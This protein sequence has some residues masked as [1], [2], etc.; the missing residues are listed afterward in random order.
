M[1]AALV[2]SYFNTGGFASAGITSGLCISGVFY[3]ETCGV[4]NAFLENIIRDLVTYAEH[5]MRTTATAMDMVYTLKR[6]GKTLPMDSVVKQIQQSTKLLTFL[7]Q[8]VR[9]EAAY[10][11]ERSHTQPW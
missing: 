2:T 6:Q 5:A 8:P 4:L 11:Q 1:R 9:A 7:L 3:E 10:V